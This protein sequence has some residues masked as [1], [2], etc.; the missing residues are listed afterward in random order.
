MTI[1]YIEKEISTR[2]FDEGWIKPEPPQQRT[3]KKIAVVGSGPAGLAAAQQL[4]RAGH[5][6]TVFERADHIGGLLIFGI[7]DFKLE[8]D[9]VRRRIVLMAEEGISFSTGVNVGVDY[10]VDTLLADYDAVCLACGSTEARDL[11]V[12]G[13]G[14]NGVHLAMEYLTQQNRINAGQEIDPADR[15]YGDVGSI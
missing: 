2:G 3:G 6:V 7:P 4:N 12:P 8:K 1:E 14:L 10:A 5:W 9:V 11:P 15:I 13:R